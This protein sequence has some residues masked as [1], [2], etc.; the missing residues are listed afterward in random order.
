MGTNSNFSGEVTITPPLTWNEIKAT[1][2]I[3]LIGTDSEVRLDI[4]EQKTDTPDGELTIKTCSRIIP[5]SAS[6]YRGYY[7]QEA[8]QAAI[9][10]NPG[11]I[12]AGH[13]EAVLED[14]S[15]MCRF[16][17]RDGKVRKVEPVWPD[18]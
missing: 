13:I 14:G 6:P 15:Y 4:T 17:V 5:T 12:F 8:L 9:D 16:L 18:E 1:Q 3:K 7:V 10:Q 2:L 11:H